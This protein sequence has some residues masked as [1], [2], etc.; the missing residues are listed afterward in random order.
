ML[1]SLLTAY[2]KAGDDDPG[3]D[4]Y[5]AF[6]PCIIRAY[7]DAKDIMPDTGEQLDGTTA[8]A[9][10]FLSW[11]EFRFLN[12]EFV[13]RIYGYCKASER[14]GGRATHSVQRLSKRR[15]GPRPTHAT[16]AVAPP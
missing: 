5:D 3:R 8:T 13:L 14:A 15:T 6:R 1:S 12:S 16:T 4:L 10:D 2:P 7:I 11:G 9:D